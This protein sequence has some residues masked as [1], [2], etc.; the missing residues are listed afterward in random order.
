MNKRVS[1]VLTSLPGKGTRCR[2]APP[3]EGARTPGP[4]GV[5]RGLHGATRLRGAGPAGTSLS[6]CHQKNSSAFGMDMAELKKTFC[7]IGNI[8]IVLKFSMGTFRIET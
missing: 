7:P 4:G 2:Q 5:G 8:L 6:T 1:K 3:P